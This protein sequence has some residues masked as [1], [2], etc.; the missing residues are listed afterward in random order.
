[1]RISDW[2]SDVC[3]SD[4]WFVLAVLLVAVTTFFVWGWFG[5]EPACTFAVLNA[6]SVLI[7]ACPCALGLATPM[8]ILVA[9]GRAAPA[10]VLFR[11]AAAIEHLPQIATLLLASSK[12]RR[13]G[14]E[15]VRQF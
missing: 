6:V 11:D 15:G 1:M 4:L 5:P 12:E 3:S 13:V 9:P 7:I 10:G 8:S 14:K 2:S